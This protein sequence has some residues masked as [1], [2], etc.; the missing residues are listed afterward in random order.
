MGPYKATCMEVV[1]Q[2]YPDFDSVSF[3]LCIG[4]AASVSSVVCASLLVQDFDGWSRSALF[5]YDFS[6][7]CVDLLYLSAFQVV[8]ISLATVLARKAQHRPQ[9]S[10]NHND[11]NSK[12][13]RNGFFRFL[14]RKGFRYMHLTSSGD[15]KEPLLDQG[16]EKEDT[17][18]LEE[19]KQM[20]ISGKGGQEGYE[21]EDERI[22]DQF[23]RKID[24]SDIAHKKSAEIV[25]S[26]SIALVFMI[27]TGVQVYTGLKCIS[28]EY[29]DE[30]SQGA[31]MGLNV[32]WI[33][34]IVWVSRELIKK[35]PDETGIMIPELHKHKLHL[36]LNAHMHW[37]DLC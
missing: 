32:L 33:N 29:D 8:S 30:T 20:A 35:G 1:Q 17:G 21:D 4:G 14:F 23:H 13:K 10:T 37:C 31:M 12:E 28:F 34:L 24:A 5:K 19:T 6:H 22:N 27:S 36:D 18:K 11:N 25:K 9:K 26:Y 2:Y 3:L 16:V 15:T 7:G